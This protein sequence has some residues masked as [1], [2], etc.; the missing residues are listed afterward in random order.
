MSQDTVSQ[1][2]AL[3]GIGMGNGVDQLDRQS[4]VVN[5]A[6]KPDATMEY[7][8]SPI[9]EMI[10]TFA[11]VFLGAGSVVANTLSHGA[12][13]TVGV[14]LAHGLALALVISIFGATSGGHINP[15]VTIGFL[16]TGRIKVGRAALYILG[17][18]I[19]AVLAGL[20][21]RGI[22]PA[23][24]WQSAM[25]GTPALGSGVSAGTGVVVEIILTAFLVFAVFGTAV[26][27]R[28]PKIGGFGIGLMVMVDI[29][30][31][32][33]L[34][35][36]AMNPAR[37]FGPA[38]AGGYW[39]NQWIYWVGPIIGA[40]IAALIYHWIVLRPSKAEK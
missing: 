27:P 25:L 40:I 39:T 14:A 22:F 3:D 5:E 21:L 37:A 20:V 6:A 26:D 31:G 17:Q 10:G 24:D 7:V 1:Q 11:F 33:V 2:K 29:L 30:A 38:L 9:A 18:L 8:I 16:V 19:G 15:A 12:L 35:G 32:G 34:S 23:M 36:A 13:G 28:A 4:A